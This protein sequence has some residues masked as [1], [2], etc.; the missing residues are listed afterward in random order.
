MSKSKNA[1]PNKGWR[2]AFAG[3]GVNLA[4]GVL[5]S[6]G[7]FQTTL[8][9]EYGWSATET[10]VPY[11]IAC[12]IFATSMV[13]G[14]RLQDRIGPKTVIMMAGVAALIGLLLSGY[15]ITPVGLSISF[16]IIFGLAMGF[17]YAAPTPAAVKW[18]GPHKRGLISGIVVS[19][20]GLAGLYIA[21]LARYLLEAFGLSQTFIILGIAY[22]IVIIVLAQL[23]SN[24]PAAYVPEPPP[25]HLASKFAAKAKGVV[26]DYEWKQMIK[27]PQFFG[28]WSM[29]CI[30]TLAGLLIIGQLRSIG[31]EQAGLSSDMAFW[32]IS[33]YAIFN[34]AGRIGCGIIS[35][36]IGPRLTL[37]LMF[38]L[39]VVA[40][41]LFS[42]FVTAVPLFIGTS[43]VAFTFG[44]M[45]TIF[46]AISADYFGVKNLGVNYGLVFTAWGGGGVFGPLLGGIVRDMTGTYGIAYAV[47]AILSAVGIVLALTM[48]AP[49]EIYE[50]E[51]QRTAS[52]AKSS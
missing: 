23:I 16:G 46:P 17:G 50:E 32:L 11:M 36:K 42:T 35:D 7:A 18:F 8:V 49:K 24:P 48:K 31:L 9:Q 28:L 45:L 21:P 40:F 52:P 30:G 12:F 26:V 15:L 1:I 4:L 20:F 2:V 37:V 41:A 13:P 34:W 33:V 6:W 38:A 22:G 51:P 43:V 14:G 29:F 5:Y 19:G 10:Q 47:S 25:P 44:G 27:T 3:M 39:Q